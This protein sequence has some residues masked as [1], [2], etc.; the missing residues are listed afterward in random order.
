MIIGIDPG[1]DGAIATIGDDGLQ[2]TVMPTVEVNGRR[3]INEPDLQVLL[4]SRVDQKPRVVIELVSAMPSKG[5]EGE[6]KRGMGATSAF[7]FGAGWGFIRGL[8][9]G[10]G[11]SY[12]LVRPQE[13]Q[14]LMLAGQAK[15]SEFLVASRLWPGIDWRKSTRA[16]LPHDGKVD[17]ALI[18]EW[19]RR[20]GL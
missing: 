7:S 6:A 12:T 17:A 9:C 19:G 8:C 18:A 11:L 20:A 10:L 4:R 3:S 15:G 14:K 5:K 2:L 13:W 1:M 16:R